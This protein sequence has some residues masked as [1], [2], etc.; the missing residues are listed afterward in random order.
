MAFWIRTVFIRMA[1]LDSRLEFSRHLLNTC[2]WITPKEGVK[3][4]F[5]IL[6]LETKDAIHVHDAAKNMMAFSFVKA[7]TVAFAC[8]MALTRPLTDDIRRCYSRMVAEERVAPPQETFRQ[9]R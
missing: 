3:V 6:N 2:R 5:W 4:L 7:T 1:V 9:I 8:A